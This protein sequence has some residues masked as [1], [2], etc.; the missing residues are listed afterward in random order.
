MTE[1]QVSSQKQGAK[2]LPSP[3][4]QQ[5]E[6]AKRACVKKKGPFYSMGLNTYKVPMALYE[7]NRVRLV[8]SILE[9]LQAG[10][11]N[12]ASSS[13]SKQLPRGLILLKVGQL[14]TR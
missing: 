8:Q 9:T 1:N 14:L 10:S 11:N 5:I 3:Q 12:D 6:A 2:S 4:Q 7:L 13:S